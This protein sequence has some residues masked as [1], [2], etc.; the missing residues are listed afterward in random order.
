MG[1]RGS[2]VLRVVHTQALDGRFG[3]TY[4]HIFVDGEGRKSK[5]FATGRCLERGTYEIKATVKKHEVYQERKETLLT[6]CSVVREI[7]VPAA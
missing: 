1:K 2:F 3:I 4:L 7:A 5:W 6:R